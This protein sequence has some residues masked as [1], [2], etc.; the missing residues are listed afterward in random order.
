MLNTKQSTTHDIQPFGDSLNSYKN[1]NFVE[2]ETPEGLQAALASIHINF[3]VLSIYKNGSK[4]IAWI[5]P[6]RKLTKR[7]QE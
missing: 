5:L 6:M 2:S 4:H 3:K 1:I 7:G